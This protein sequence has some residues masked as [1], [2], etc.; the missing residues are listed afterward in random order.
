MWGPEP[1]SSQV[2]ALRLFFLRTVLRVT[3]L[4]P[5]RAGRYQVELDGE[6]AAST[7]PYDEL[8]RLPAR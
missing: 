3:A 8:L 4:T 1:Y 6:P 5:V 7:Q 2:A